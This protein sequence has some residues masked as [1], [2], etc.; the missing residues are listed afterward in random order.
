MDRFPKLLEQ[1]RM[2]SI[3]LDNRIIMAPMGSLNCD[4]NGY[5]TDNALALY[6][7][8]AKGGMGMIIVE[9]TATDD[10]L[11]RGHRDVSL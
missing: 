6:S 3:R 5:I 1:A 11:S 4:S 9:C 2:G 8:Q 10:D 7:S